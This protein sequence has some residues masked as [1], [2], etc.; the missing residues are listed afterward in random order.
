MY[1]PFSI[2]WLEKTASCLTGNYHLNYY[3]CS[4]VS[5]TLRYTGSK[6]FDA[7]EVLPGVYV[8]DVYAA[9]NADEL[10]K[11][12]I[13]HVVNAVLGV[14]PPYPEKF[15]YM[16]VQL[17]DYPG[18]NI[19]DHLQHTSKFIEDALA[20]G[21]NVLIHC[22]KGVSRSA[23]IAAAFAIYSQKLSTKEAIALLK[24]SRTI[25]R[26]NHGFVMQLEWY[27]KKLIETAKQQI[28]VS[29]IGA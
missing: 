18:E 28:A 8:G 2:E 11:R 3:Y 10:K 9:H 1:K 7:H 17:L 14:T 13:T 4:A 24:K 5:K 29:S 20:G 19:Q 22:L 6:A 21:G 27:E 16:H 12:N 23:S 25:I 15:K 26:P